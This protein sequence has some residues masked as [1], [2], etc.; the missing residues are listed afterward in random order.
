M[1]ITK[2][3]LQS[4]KM[5]LTKKKLKK[6]ISLLCFLRHRQW[7]KMNEIFFKFYKTF[8]W[9]HRI[10]MEFLERKGLI[11]DDP[12]EQYE[13]IER[14]WFDLYPRNKNK[15]LTSSGFEHV[16][17][18][19]VKR[20]KIIG[21]HNWIYFAEGERLG[22]LNYKGWVKIIDLGEVRN[23]KY[24]WDFNFLLTFRKQKSSKWSLVSTV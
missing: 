12:R 8:F 6:M 1:T 3:T 16:F 17:L 24:S 5:L 7:S 11:S 2:Q 18:S 19:E 9:F 23:I 15:T 20:G 4:M 14:I 13:L 22:V 21:L 10:A